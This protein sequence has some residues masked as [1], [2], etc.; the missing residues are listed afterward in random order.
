MACAAVMR[1]LRGHDPLAIP[2]AMPTEHHVGH[3]MPG[4][5]QNIA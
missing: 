5:K 2:N 1:C 4:L 3:R